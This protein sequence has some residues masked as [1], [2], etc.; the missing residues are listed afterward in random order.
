MRSVKRENSYI[1]VGCVQ[2]PWG[3]KV[4]CFVDDV[5]KINRRRF[6]IWQDECYQDQYTKI[7]SIFR[8]L[9]ASRKIDHDI[10]SVLIH[11]PIPRG[12]RDGFFVTPDLMA[13]ISKPV[14][15]RMSLILSIMA[16]EGIKPSNFDGFQRTEAEY[17]VCRRVKKLFG[18]EAQ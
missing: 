12:F 10:S 6:I 8:Q 1:Q 2:S 9:L 13:E 15:A 14:N 5:G 17:R 11:Q 7:S 4:S 3:R 16:E 18:E